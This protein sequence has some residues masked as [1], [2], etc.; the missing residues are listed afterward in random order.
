MP[1]RIPLLR[2]VLDHA[3]HIG[4]C[5]QVEYGPEYIVQPG[6]CGLLHRRGEGGIL[7]GK[8]DAR[9]NVDDQFKLGTGLRSPSPDRTH[10]MTGVRDFH[11]DDIPAVA[12][13]HRVAMETA[14]AMTPAL[15][16]E[17]RA[18]LTSVFLE[19]PMRAEGLGSL[20]YEDHGRIVAFLGVLTRRVRINRREFLGSSASNFC[21]DPAHRGMVGIQLASQYLARSPDLAITDEI[22][23]GAGR[24]VW[25]FCGMLSM[26]QS[27]RW[28]LPLA[29]LSHVLSR[30]EHAFPA[31][32]SKLS[33]LLAQP[34]DGLAR[35]AP[36][37]PYRYDASLLVASELGVDEFARLLE[38][39]GPNRLLRPVI[40]DGSAAWLIHRARSLRNRG[41]LQ[42]VVVRDARAQVAGWF[43][44]HAR[45]GRPSEVL[46][47]V[48]ATAD[49]ASAV[50]DHLATHALAHDV[51]S[52]T[53]T[54]DLKFLAPLGRRWASFKADP[55]R[56]M[57]VHST[58]QE[59]LEAYWRGNL[60]LS[61]LDGEWCQFFR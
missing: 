49:V 19:N 21:V 47:L 52:L 7:P 61:R 32:V 3:T 13:L 10:D 28:T 51:V 46:Q 45:P 58:H 48:A 27:V 20:V 57:M 31:P 38:S 6:A 40:S 2:F 23:D 17:Y 9:R 41:P 4:V 29:P 54:L 22:Q 30:V 15:A 18:W 44:Y 11:E 37:S 26:P 34:I 55:A 50:L 5:G 43:V 1:E 33:R 14:P 39:W 53:G 12:D 42:L 60:L 8:V 36:R 59:V 16:D 25:E 35:R 24:K 56:W